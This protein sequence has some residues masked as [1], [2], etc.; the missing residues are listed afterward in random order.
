MDNS[1]AGGCP[2]CDVEI[3]HFVP[4]KRILRKEYYVRAERP[5]GHSAKIGALS[6][7][8]S[9]NEWIKNE[10]SDWLTSWQT[11]K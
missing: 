7:K 2:A 5:D 10:S 3:P 9:A 8:A 1:T 11:R 6:E 4:R